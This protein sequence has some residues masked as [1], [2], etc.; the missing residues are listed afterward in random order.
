M[1]N[2]NA[3]I[4]RIKRTRL[5][6]AIIFIVLALATL[7][8]AIIEVIPKKIQYQEFNRDDNTSHYVKA[9]IKYLT[10]PIIEATDTKTK[11]KFKYYIATGINEELFIV[12]TGEEIEL[13]V[14]GKDVTQEN[15]DAV[16][17]TEIYGIAELTSGSLITALSDGL[18]TIFQEQVANSHN[19][20]EV[21]GAYHFDTVGKTTNI[22]KN[23][24]IVAAILALLGV[25]Y[26]YVNIKIRKRVEIALEELTQK[27]KLEEV[28]NEYEGG[29]LIEYRKVRASL[30][31]QYL[32]SYI[33]GID[34]IE[35]RNI[36]EVTLSKKQFGN[37]DKNKYIIV[38]TKEDREYYIAPFEK[39]AQKVVANELL[40]KL[41]SMIG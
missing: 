19:L 29:Q 20:S 25:L 30:S 23:L 35:I 7:I 11:E 31:P 6:E 3:K 26:L 16:S 13:P 34:I 28:I 27:G 24:F 40:A 38:A 4:N 1:K 37:R 41:K 9:K 10:G 14:Y 39:R 2:F 18:N 17:E 33:N 15:I 8:W 32:F 36:K 5:F 21:M 12:K 22:A